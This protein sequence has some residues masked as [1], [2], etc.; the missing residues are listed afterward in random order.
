VVTPFEVPTPTPTPCFC[1]KAELRISPEV[2]Q[3]G[4]NITVSA[5]LPLVGG[6]AGDPVDLY[7]LA[8]APWGTTYSVLPNNVIVEGLVPYYSGE[9][10]EAVWCGVLYSH[11]ACRLIGDYTLLLGMMPAGIPPSRRD[12]IDYDW[13]VLKLIP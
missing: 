12:V 2:V 6:V 7:L 10:N 9:Y 4:D 8:K 1:Q 13:G 5:C 11:R 3:P